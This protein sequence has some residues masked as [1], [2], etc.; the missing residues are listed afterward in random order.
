MA[1][2]AVDWSS[3]AL[4]WRF[5]PGEA[6]INADTSGALPV[7]RGL[8]S[9]PLLGAI[10]DASALVLLVLAGLWLARTAMAGAAVWTGCALMWA[11]IGS[12]AMDRWGGHLWLAPGSKRGVVDWIGVS[13]GASIN[14]ADVVIGVGLL[15]AIAALAATRIPRSARAAVAAGVVLLV[16]FSMLTAGG[17]ASNAAA[18]AAARPSLAQQ[19]RASMW[20][21]PEHEGRRVVWRELQPGLNLAVDAVD[22][23][24][25][26]LAQWRLP[27]D[28]DVI[29]LPLPERTDKVYVTL[30]DKGWTITLVD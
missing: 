19:V 14:L 8:V 2:L 30:V 1:V 27:S 10:V 29:M 26:V 16:P 20:V 23:N 7:L 11:G 22:R 4:A 12:N 13:A 15:L 9:H 5:L 21:G 18:R 24:G 3:K 25:L 6:I 28:S 17:S